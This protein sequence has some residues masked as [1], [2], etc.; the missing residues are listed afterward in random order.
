MQPR[1]SA[2]TARLTR[3]LHLASKANRGIGGVKMDSRRADASAGRVHENGLAMQ[4]STSVERHSEISTSSTW[5]WESHHFR[6]TERRGNLAR[7]ARVKLRR[8]QVL[9]RD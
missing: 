3:L 7:G 6:L 1:I 2:P 8:Q 4:C 5:L 9:S